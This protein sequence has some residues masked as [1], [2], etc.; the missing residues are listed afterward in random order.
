MRWS[1][2]CRRLAGESLPETRSSC[3]CGSRTGPTSGSNWATPPSPG[4]AARACWCSSST[5]PRAQT[6]RDTHRR[7]PASGALN[8]LRS[9]FRVRRPVTS[10]ARWHH[11]VLAGPVASPRPPAAGERR[12]LLA[13][14]Q[15]SVRRMTGMLD[16]VL[17]LGKAGADA[18]VQAAAAGPPPD[19]Y[20]TL[21]QE[22]AQARGRRALPN[23]CWTPPTRPPG[24]AL[25][26][27]CCAHPGQ[28]AVQHRQLP[29]PGWHGLA[30]PA[31]QTRA[32][33]L[34]VRTRASAFQAE[35]GHLF[36][37]LP[38]A[39]NVGDIRGTGLGLAIVKNAVELHRGTI[40]VRSE[41][42]RAPAS[43]S[44]WLP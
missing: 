32:T 19:L 5:S 39:S 22:R 35:L 7:W 8:A 30:A 33:V 17:L 9:S 11:P 27:C 28:P 26:Q 2:G 20:A 15:A 29:P 3:A 10:S 43:P 42:G 6:V 13:A 23:W 41:E 38:R 1:N 12:D 31:R 14:I 34:E 37:S 25:R 24:P 40:E 44:G 4:T 21:L 16:Q 36:E 18:G